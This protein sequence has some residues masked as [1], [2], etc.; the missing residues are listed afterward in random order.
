MV[1][2]AVVGGVGSEAMDRPPKRKQNRAQR[3]AKQTGAAP[4]GSTT[5]EDG[6]IVYDDDGTP[7]SAPAQPATG[8]RQTVPRPP[9]AGVCPPW[10][11]YWCDG[12]D[13]WHHH[14]EPVVD[15][16]AASL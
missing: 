8:L 11:Y 3:R 13:E 16:I 6:W 4:A 10:H 1:V 9:G 7:Q 12:H 14:E 5:N 2:L 15:V